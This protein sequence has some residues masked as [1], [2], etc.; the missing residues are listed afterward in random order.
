MKRLLWT[1]YVPSFD[2]VIGSK[3]VATC[4]ASMTFLDLKLLFCL[5]CDDLFTGNPGRALASRVIAQV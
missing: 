4:H 5:S 3:C 2:Q 1:L